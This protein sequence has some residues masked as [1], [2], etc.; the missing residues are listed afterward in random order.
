MSPEQ[1]RG[2]K[3]IDYRSDIYSLGVILFELLT[4]TPPYNGTF[5]NLM[6][7]HLS[8]PI[9][10]ICA[11]R[12]DLPTGIEEIISSTMSKKPA[13]RYASV[14]L[15]AQAV[16]DCLESFTEDEQ[17][18]QD[19]AQTS[20]DN[21]SQSDQQA[22][23]RTGPRYSGSKIIGIDLGYSS[24]SV[25]VVEGGEAT[26][27]A[28]SRGEK[29]T[30][31]V[32][33]FGANGEILVGSSAASLAVTAPERAIWGL[34]RKLGTGWQTSIDGKTYTTV[35]I[36]AL[37]FNSLRQDAEHYLGER[38]GQA[39]VAIPAPFSYQQREEVKEAAQKK[40]PI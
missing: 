5:V 22:K 30:P 24:S 34:S 35:D 21:S 26:I 28:N 11:I 40:K 23:A 1:I 27:I 37:L 18:T 13:E 2:D 6:H 38:V 19:S 36:L 33:A 39:I 12:P 14:T 16:A 29:L 17:K 31:S 9:P 25:A 20:S 4:G 10:S 8:E 32:V 7:K 15:L 3:N